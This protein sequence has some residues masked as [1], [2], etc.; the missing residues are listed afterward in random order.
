MGWVPQV[1]IL[2]H[3]SI[4]GSLFHSGWGSVIE[5]LRFGHKLVVLPF[6]MDQPLNARL[7]VDKG[8]AIEVKRNNEDG[9]FSKDD[10]AKSLREAMVLEEGEKLRVKTR[11]A[12]KVVGDLKLHQDYMASFI[13]FLKTG[14]WNKI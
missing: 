5:T 3:P 1:Q 6:T 4:G 13:Q 11:E 9:S 12:A 14:I 10:I 7:L 2:A 8:L